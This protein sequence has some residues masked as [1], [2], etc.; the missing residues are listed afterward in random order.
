MM[1]DIVSRGSMRLVAQVQAD[2][3]AESLIEQK[4]TNEIFL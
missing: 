4:S 2:T 3:S 1:V